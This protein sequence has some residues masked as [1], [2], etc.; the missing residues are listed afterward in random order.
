MSWS[1][2]SSTCLGGTSCQHC[3]QEFIICS[4]VNKLWFLTVITVI[5]T[6][7]GESKRRSISRFAVLVE[8][9]TLAMFSKTERIAK[10]WQERWSRN[11]SWSRSEIRMKWIHSDW[12]G[13][14]SSSY[15]VKWSSVQTWL[16]HRNLIQ[17]LAGKKSRSPHTPPNIG[18]QIDQFCFKRTRIKFSNIVL[19][20][21]SFKIV[22]F[23]DVAS[24]LSFWIERR[25]LT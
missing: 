5:M 14:L 21:F 15:W 19:Y 16:C 12:Y 4:C 18:I 25:N 7:A 17:I 6:W 23:Y 8:S 22:F 10:K 11:H 9:F 1:L 2:N 24:I 13:E 3:D 20:S